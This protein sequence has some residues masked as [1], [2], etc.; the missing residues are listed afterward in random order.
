M[1]Q[2]SLY[3]LVLLLRIHLFSS[4]SPLHVICR[5]PFFATTLLPPSRIRHVLFSKDA[6]GV[7]DW[8]NH[9][10]LNPTLE[11]STFLVPSQHV[12]SV[13][14]DPRVQ[15]FLAGTTTTFEGRSKI[16]L[17]QSYNDTHQL[18]LKRNSSKDFGIAH[19]PTHSLQLD[20]SYFSISN[21]LDI[22]NI[23][24]VHVHEQVGHVVLLDLLD[25][26]QDYRYVIGDVFL[27]ILPN[28]KTV[29][30]TTSD[31]TRKLDLLAGTNNT[32]VTV[33]ESGISLSFDLQ[34][35]DWNARLAAE[36][37]Y[38]ISH[39]FQDDE[40]IVDVCCGVGM[41]CLLAATKLRNTTVYAHDANPSCIKALQQASK[42][43]P[44]IHTTCGDPFEFLVDMGLEWEKLP[45]HVVLNDP[46][47][48][49]SYLNALRWWRDS[50]KRTGVIPTLHV[51][52]SVSPT[53]PRSAFLQ[54][55]IDLVAHNLLPEG[56]EPTP[57]RTDHLNR[58]KCNVRA[59]QVSDK[60]A[61]VSFK[62][63]AQLL[64]H[65]QGDFV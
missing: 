11:F 52:T 19:G 61:C 15:P 51:Y 56:N 21:I 46:N 49:P 54:S 38:L 22:L 53:I 39:E 25:H 1:R 64:R 8:K 13:L 16:R 30:Q 27:T 32:Q 44:Q 41:T 36:R 45:N 24:P 5:R 14:R 43:M 4:F 20:A 58:L 17:V 62:A 42:K 48:A 2:R 18:I 7:T 29:V 26:H 60:V 23:P 6:T 47:E 40:T 65:V 12:Q 55:A 28:V 33:V 63:T 31:N 57:N 59:R 34:E 10:A 3:I 37:Q 50:K 35:C 9:A